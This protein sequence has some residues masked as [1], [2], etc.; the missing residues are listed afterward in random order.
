MGMAFFTASF[1][2]PAFPR[3]YKAT[4]LQEGILYESKVATGFGIFFTALF[5]VAT[6]I[7]VAYVVRERKLAQQTRDDAD[8]AK[9]EVGTVAA[10]AHSTD[11]NKEEEAASPSEQDDQDQ[12]IEAQESA[13]DENDNAD[14]N[15]EQEQEQQFSNDDNDCQ[16]EE[17]EEVSPTDISYIFKIFAAIFAAPIFAFGLSFGGMAKP[18]K[19]IG[20]FDLTGFTRSQYDPSLM[21]LFAAG[22]GASFCAY[23]FVAGHGV[24]FIQ[25]RN[26]YVRTRSLSGDIYHICKANQITKSLVLGSMIFGIS[27]GIAGFCPT[28]SLIM[29][30]AGRWDAFFVWLPLFLVGRVMHMICFG[31]REKEQARQEH[32]RKKEARK[33]QRKSSRASSSRESSFESFWQRRTTHRNSSV[34]G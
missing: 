28:P 11:N 20:F 6:V 4:R 29:A 15:Q 5:C 2:S 7:N 17:E 31:R 3:I 8:N 26:P 24:S 9:V 10:T 19:I 1:C 33:K 25:S 30:L 23:Q 32:E 22:C 12:D 34:A 14:N 13:A 18:S 27:L 16:P 21:F